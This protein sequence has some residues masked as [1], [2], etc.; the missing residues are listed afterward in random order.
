MTIFAEWWHLYKSA[1]DGAVSDASNAAYLAEE[2][3]IRESSECRFIFG[4]DLCVYQNAI[5]PVEYFCYS[6]EGDDKSLADELLATQQYFLAC[7]QSSQDLD[8]KPI[9]P[10]T[11]GEER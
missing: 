9:A 1:P 5:P 8:I 7:A 4:A 3:G 11:S 2:L 10:N 6:C